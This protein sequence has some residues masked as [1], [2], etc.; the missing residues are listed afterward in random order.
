VLSAA[1]SLGGAA[2]FARLEGTLVD[3]E[4]E[5][6]VHRVNP[7][8]DVEASVGGHW[9]RAYFGAALGLAYFPTYRRYLVEGE[10]VFSPWPIAVGLR[11]YCGVDL[12]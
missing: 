6:D 12:F 8:L 4:L 10:P 1:V 9:S 2:H 3:G 5:R 7:S 11:G